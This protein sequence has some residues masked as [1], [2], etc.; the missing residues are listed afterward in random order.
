MC[1]V[2]MQRISLVEIAHQRVAEVLTPGGI[3]IDATLGNGYDSVFLAG[4][5]GQ[6]GQ[7]YGFDIQQQALNNTRQR[8]QEAGLEECAHLFLA[9][10][11]LLLDFL[12]VAKRGQIQAIMFNLGYLPGADK[13]VITQEQTTVKALA[14]ATELLAAPGVLTILAYPGHQGG[15]QE[16]NAVNDFCTYLSQR[17]GF[18]VEIIYST[19][20][21]PKAPLLIVVNKTVVMV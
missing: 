7:V 14:A 15:E 19:Y 5:V 20:Q 21:T 12:P 8:L 13:T 2:I 16:L 6:T 4:C 3:A 18:R 1:A 17:S 9:C 11:S 10:H